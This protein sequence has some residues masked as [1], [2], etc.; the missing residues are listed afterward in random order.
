M[1]IKH[2]EEAVPTRQQGEAPLVLSLALLLGVLKLLMLPAMYSKPDVEMLQ[3]SRV[4]I[5]FAR[6][7]ETR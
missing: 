3:N 1:E 6:L 7:V 2:L 5:F 4:S